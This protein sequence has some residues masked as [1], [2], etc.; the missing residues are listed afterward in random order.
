MNAWRIE[1]AAFV[2]RS[3]S[4]SVALSIARRIAAVARR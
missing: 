1:S 3:S 2:D 4:A